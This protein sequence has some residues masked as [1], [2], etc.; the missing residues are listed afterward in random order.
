MI[1]YHCEYTELI[2]PKTL[3]PHPKNANKHPKS[4]VKALAEV[5]SR[6]GWRRC[7][8]VSNRSGYIV[9]GHCS[10]MSGIEL[11]CQVP[12]DYQDFANETEEL[13][14]LMADN[15]IPELAEWD[16]ELQLSNL[17]ELEFSDITFEIEDVD[18]NP[19]IEIPDIKIDEKIALE[20]ITV[21]AEEHIKKDVIAEFRKIQAKYE[22]GMFRIVT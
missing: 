15:I 10:T 19:D 1:K 9:A 17:K 16:K 3:N 12:I 21:F 13:D 6:I 4:Q 7:I 18:S 11:G 8:V 5:I 2:D 22:D 20:K 14:F